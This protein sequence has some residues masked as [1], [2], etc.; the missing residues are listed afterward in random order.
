MNK[1]TRTDPT[2]KS[3]GITIPAQ[4]VTREERTEMKVNE[5]TKLMNDH[6][7]RP[8][9]KVLKHMNDCTLLVFEGKPQNM[10]EE[11]E[12]LKVN[13]FTVLGKG[14]LEIHAQ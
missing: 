10:G 1:R 2:D 5:L 8:R 3:L 13:S 14:F 11:I 6:G 7:T 9:I 12:K 4:E